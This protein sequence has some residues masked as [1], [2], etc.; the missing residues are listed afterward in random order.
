MLFNKSW[1]LCVVKFKLN[2]WLSGKTSC[3][4]VDYVHKVWGKFFY[5]WIIIDLHFYIVLILFNSEKKIRA[6]FYP[7]YYICTVDLYSSMSVPHKLSFLKKELI[8]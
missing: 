2:Q 6:L 5:Y 1:M 4:H 8:L 7:V 3:I